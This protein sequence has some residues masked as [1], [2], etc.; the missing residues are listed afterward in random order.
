MHTHTAAIFKR[1]T[2]N[3]LNIHHKEIYVSWIYTLLS[4]KLCNDSKESF[5][6][7]LLTKK[8]SQDIINEGKKV[9]EH[10]YFPISHV[11][12]ENYLFPHIP[13]IDINK[14]IGKRLVGKLI[15]IICRKNSTTGERQSRETYKCI[16]VFYFSPRFS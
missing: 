2:R 13:Y 3:N 6:F 14:Y 11:K 5:F 15:I 10:M 7:F 4:E 12:M 9:V 16:P 1:K 8:H